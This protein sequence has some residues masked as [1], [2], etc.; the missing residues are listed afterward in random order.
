M[1]QEKRYY[2]GLEQQLGIPRSLLQ[3]SPGAHVAV[4]LQALRSG[5]SA[6]GAGEDLEILSS[7]R[8]AQKF[9]EDVQDSISHL[10][11]GNHC[12]TI[13]STLGMNTCASTVHQPARESARHAY[14]SRHA[15]LVIR[16]QEVLS[17][18]T[19]HW[20]TSQFTKAA[21]TTFIERAQLLG[22]E[23]GD[24][25]ID[26]LAEASSFGDCV[27]RH[28]ILRAL[29]E[30]DGAKLNAFDWEGPS[31]LNDAA[32][33]EHRG[34]ELWLPDRQVLRAREE[35]DKRWIST[36]IFRPQDNCRSWGPR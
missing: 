3:V 5:W 18:I 8:W 35:G 4:I 10:V 13:V 15:E 6:Y 14:A 32:H 26:L 1:T 7:G 2:P 22:A 9:H 12:L 24:R 23:R 20:C 28:Q 17:D 31:Y 33:L 11:A 25:A 16:G 36:E 19:G 27:E 29:W 21:R 34:H 30:G